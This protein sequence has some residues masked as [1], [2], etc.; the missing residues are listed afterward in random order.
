MK[1]FDNHVT[2]ESRGGLRTTNE[3]HCGVWSLRRLHTNGSISVPV[4]DIGET[5]T[6]NELFFDISGFR[7]VRWNEIP[8]RSQKRSGRCGGRYQLPFWNWHTVY[9]GCLS[10]KRRYSEGNHDS[11]RLDYSLS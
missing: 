9:H 1:D 10:K 11:E 3:N 7:K 5:T 4:I 6:D 2:A 8:F